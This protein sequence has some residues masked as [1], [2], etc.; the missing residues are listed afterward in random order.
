MS[1]SGLERS[2]TDAL[3]GGERVGFVIG[4]GNVAG[5]RIRGTFRRSNAPHH[6]SDGVNVEHTTGVITTDTGDVIVYELRGMAV[7]MDPSSVER[8]IFAAI[9][10]RTS[11]PEHAWLN[12]VFAVAEA[13]YDGKGGGT[14]YRVYECRPDS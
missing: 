9:T 13:R 7:R 1:G 12:S 10:F 11:A 2:Y 3:A 5:E 6:R 14:E 8:Q 4:G